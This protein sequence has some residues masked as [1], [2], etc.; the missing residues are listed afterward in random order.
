MEIKIKKLSKE[1][2]IPKYQTDGSIAFDLHSIADVTWR[3]VEPN[4]YEAIVDTGLAFEVPTGYGMFIF[5]RSGTGFKYNVHLAN[6]TG[7]IDSDYRGEVKIKLIAIT[8]KK[9]PTF[10][11]K[12]RVAQA[13]IIPILNANFIE[14]DDLSQTERGDGGFGSTGKK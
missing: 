8:D 6:G 13:S 9:P 7:L 10:L 5:P 11:A 4:L 3:F 1:A 14:V 12:D 2:L